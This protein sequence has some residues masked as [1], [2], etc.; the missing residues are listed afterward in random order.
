MT[1]ILLLIDTIYWYQFRYN[2]LKDKKAFA[3]FF[4]SFVKSRLKF[5]HFEKKVDPHRFCISEITDSKNI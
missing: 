2:Y 3:Q 5:E 1:S 4:S